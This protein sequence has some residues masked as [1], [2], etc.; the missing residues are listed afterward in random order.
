MLVM[1]IGAGDLDTL[2][3]CKD[4]NEALQEMYQRAVAPRFGVLDAERLEPLMR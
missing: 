4:R 3:R 1:L 2:I